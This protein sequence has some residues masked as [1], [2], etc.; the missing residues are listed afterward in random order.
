MLVGLIVAIFLI[1]LVLGTAA[2]KVARDLQRE[3]EVEAEHRANQYVRA[4]QLYYR[5]FGHYPGSMDQLEKSNNIRFLRQQYV[6]PM[7]GKADWRM[8][9]VGENKTTVKG[10]FGQPLTG[11]TPGL[12]TAAGMASPGA[13]GAGAA[14]SSSPSAFGSSSLGTGGLGSSSGSRLE[15]DQR[16]RIVDWQY[17]GGN[18]WSLRH[19]PLPAVTR[20]LAPAAVQG[21]AAGLVASRRRALRAGVLRLWGLGVRRRA[22]RLSSRTNRRPTRRGNFCTIRGSNSSRRRLVCLAVLRQ[23]LALRGWGRPR[24]MLVRG[25]VE[26]LPGRLL[27]V[28]LRLVRRPLLRPLL[29][30]LQLL[31]SK[32]PFLWNCGLRFAFSC[33]CL[34]YAQKRA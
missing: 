18:V 16:V 4:I 24:G 31:L 33:E 28:R 32:V 27:P 19:G 8:I 21:R 9:K 5:K 6:D 25:W 2:P 22:T 26:V 14:G 12:G 7:T 1:L 23:R 29:R 11:L 34:A 30:L 15:H 17:W 13:I 10:F 20:L 3:R